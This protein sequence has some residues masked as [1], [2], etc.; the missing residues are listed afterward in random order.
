MFVDFCMFPDLQMRPP[1]FDP[2]F[3]RPA[4]VGFTACPPIPGRFSTVETITNE[5]SKTVS[6]LESQPNVVVIRNID[7]LESLGGRIGVVLGLQL[8]P[9]DKT[10]EDIRR[11]R[12]MGIL[13]CTLAYKD[14]ENPYGGGYMTDRPLTEEG[15]KFLRQLAATGIVADLSHASHPMAQDVIDVIRKQPGLRVMA[16]HGGAYSVYDN[17]RNLPDDILADIAERGGIVGLYNLTFGLERS[18][19]SL[20]PWVRHLD[21]MIEVCGISHVALGTDGIY[22]HIPEDIAREQFERMQRF[23]PSDPRWPVYLPTEPPS[24][25]TPHKAEMIEKKLRYL[26]GEDAEAVM[27]GNAL[28]FLREVLQ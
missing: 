15:R 19:S 24:L 27:A 26:L 14:E 17:P 9:F 10:L 1:V 21:R 16:S 13:F 22:R 20:G 12:Q 4:I 18:D 11:L 25:N 23:A 8:P 3:P 7:D 6:I 5:V 2:D 28:R